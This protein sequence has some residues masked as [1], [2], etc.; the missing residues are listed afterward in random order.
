MTEVRF[1]ADYIGQPL[2]VD[3]V[4]FLEP[5]GYSVF[6]VYAAAES[7]VRQALFTDAL[8]VSNQMRDRLVAANGNR[9]CGWGVVS[10]E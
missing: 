7:E 8:F 1:I 5:L 4:E 2:F 9:A 3:L 10:P 6:N